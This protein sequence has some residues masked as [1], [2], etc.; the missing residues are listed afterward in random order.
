MPAA[1]TPVG[2]GAVQVAGVVMALLVTALGVAA[3]RDAVVATGLL[4][5]TPWVLGAVESLDGLRPAP[6]ALAVGVVLVLVGL[7]LVVSA[8]RPRPRTGLALRAD[9]GVFLRPRGVSRLATA[10]AEDVDGVLDASAAT[11][12]RAVS[13]RVTTTGDD[14]TSA[15]VRDTVSARLAHLDP[16]PTVKVRTRSEG[17]R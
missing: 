4:G 9:T 1:K 10:A 12:R 5:G 15:A 16:T 14:S 8:L 6:W 2:T 17:A 3:L 7:W 11:T 13:V